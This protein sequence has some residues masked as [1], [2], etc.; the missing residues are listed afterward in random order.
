MLPLFCLGLTPRSFWSK[1]ME[2][3]RQRRDFPLPQEEC[4]AQGLRLATCLCSKE[5]PDIHQ[6]LQGLRTA[7]GGTFPS[8][9]WRLHTLLGVGLKPQEDSPVPHPFPLRCHFHDRYRG[10]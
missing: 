5:S 6:L 3:V 10:L 9:V 2:V 8:R 1:L 4:Q 7:G